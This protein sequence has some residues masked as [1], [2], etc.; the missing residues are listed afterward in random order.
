MTHTTVAEVTLPGTNGH[1]SDAARRQTAAIMRGLGSRRLHFPGARSFV[2]NG[3][4]VTWSGPEA[5]CWTSGLPPTAEYPLSGSARLH[6]L[7]DVTLTGPHARRRS[8]T[9]KVPTR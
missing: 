4:S 9:R 7:R 8:R 3:C 2:C 1:P 5:D 6:L